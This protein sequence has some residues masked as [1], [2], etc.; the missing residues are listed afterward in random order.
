[1]HTLAAPAL[2]SR[3]GDDDGKGIVDLVADVGKEMPLQ[4]FGLDQAAIDVLEPLGRHPQV[5]ERAVLLFDPGGKFLEELLVGQLMHEIS[6]GA[7]LPL[8]DLDAVDGLG[9]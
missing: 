3:H 7:R 8:A 5:E 2:I 6:R 4:G 1:L 9:R